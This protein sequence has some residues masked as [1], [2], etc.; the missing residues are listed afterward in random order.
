MRLPSVVLALCWLCHP[1]IAEEM[2]GKAYKSSFEIAGKQI[3]L[4]DGQ[5]RVIAERNE[6]AGVDLASDGDL[7]QVVLLQLQGPGAAAVIVATANIGPSTTGWGTSRDC[8]RQDIL[9]ATLL[10]QP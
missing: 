7:R 3:P 6:P 1:A 10:F 5:W 4:P 2:V 8:T 9:M